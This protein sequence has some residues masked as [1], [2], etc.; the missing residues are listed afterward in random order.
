MS[1]PKK[2]ILSSFAVSCLPGAPDVTETPPEI[3]YSATKWRPGAN[4]VART[5]EKSLILLLPHQPVAP[6]TTVVAGL[7]V[8]DCHA[9]KNSLCAVIK[10]HA[11]EWWAKGNS[12]VKV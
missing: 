2:S 1:H 12:F 4:M 5:P 6:R 8:L 11:T 10:F 9:W 3:T 7:P